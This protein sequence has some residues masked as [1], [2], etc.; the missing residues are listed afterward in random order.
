MDIHPLPPEQNTFFA[1]FFKLL[2][3]E[4]KELIRKYREGNMGYYDYKCIKSQ[5]QSLDGAVK[6]LKFSSS[7]FKFFA[8]CLDCNWAYF[9]RLY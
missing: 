2:P 6:P 4:H 7:P 8:N 5:S 1:K 3:K 9:S